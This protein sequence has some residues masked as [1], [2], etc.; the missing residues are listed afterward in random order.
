MEYFR[1]PAHREGIPEG[2]QVSC[3]VRQ[4]AYPT[5]RDES[6][7]HWGV[8]HFVGYKRRLGVLEGWECT[9]QERR[10]RSGEEVRDPWGRRHRSLYPESS[11]SHGNS[12]TRKL[13][14]H[15]KSQGGLVNIVPDSQKPRR[16]AMAP[17]SVG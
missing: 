3:E 1:A 10:H 8:R 15:E 6:A 17:S 9:S 11:G 5:Y 2:R 14:T 13:Q 12:V 7:I 16:G 4:V